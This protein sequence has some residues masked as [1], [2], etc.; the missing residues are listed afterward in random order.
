MRGHAGIVEMLIRN[1]ARV[2][3]EVFSRQEGAEPA[4]HLAVEGGH[5]SYLSCC[6][7]AGPW[8]RIQRTKRAWR[9]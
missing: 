3:S 4:L 8:M 1:G 7:G 5:E 2:H 9:R 6:F